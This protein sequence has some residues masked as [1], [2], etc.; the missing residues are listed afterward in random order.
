MI[1]LN[2]FVETNVLEIVVESPAESL[3]SSTKM[4]N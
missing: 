2:G 4:L 3:Y 1:K